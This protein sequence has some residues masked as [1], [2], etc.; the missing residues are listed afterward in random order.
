MSDDRKI[1]RARRLLASAQRL[2]ILTGAGISAESGVVT[3]RQP[4]GLWETS[5]ADQVATAEGFAADPAGVWRWYHDRR[6]EMAAAQP[7]AAHVALAEL[8]RRVTAR[9]GELTLITQNVDGLHAKAGS[10]NI[11]HVHG[12]LADVRCTRCEFRQRVGMGP[13]EDLPTCP[14]C[15]AVLRPDVVWFG[16]PLPADAWQAAV[17]AC[18]ACDLFLTIGTSASVYPAAGLI[19]LAIDTGAKTIEINI[20]PTPVSGLVDIALQG[21]AGEILPQIVA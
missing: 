9:R 17:R 2:S 10:R 5:P 8:E 14:H 11:I 12:C 13:I 18:E 21:P 20:T 1:H 16:E 7:N 3:F 15:Q 19:E 4:G 6:R